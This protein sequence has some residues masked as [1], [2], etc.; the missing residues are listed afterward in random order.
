M[1]LR[2]LITS[3]LRNLFRKRE[4]DKQ[5]D[6]EVHAYVDMLTD[7]RIAAGMSASEARRSAQTEFGGVEQVKQAVRNHRAGARLELIWQDTRFGIRQLRRNPGFTVTVILT[8]ALSIGANTAIFSVV[9]A[10]MIRTLPYVD[11]ERI[12]AVFERV[13]GARPYDERTEIDGERWE[14]LRDQVPALTAAVSGGVSGV[15]LQAGPRI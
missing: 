8:L 1:R 4:L 9:N 2:S 10:L 3:V 11:P 12:G 13:G 6:D 5:L 7:E 14:L 15:N